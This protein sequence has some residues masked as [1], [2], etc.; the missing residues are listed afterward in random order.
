MIFNLGRNLLYSTVSK[1]ADDTKNTSKIG[2]TDDSTNFQNELDNVVYPWAPNNN[3]CLNGDKFEHHRIC[4]KF[5]IEKHIY[6]KPTGKNIKEKEH[7]KDLGVHI[8]NDLTWTKQINEVV[9]KARSMLGWTMKTFQTRE[10][11]PMSTI[12]NSLVRPYLNYCSPLWSQSPS[13]FREIDHRGEI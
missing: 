4:I 6:K 13:N 12:L 1:Y 10:R 7:I 9:S 8:S 11:V 2:N 3:L 5:G